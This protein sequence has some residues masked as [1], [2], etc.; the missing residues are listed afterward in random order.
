MIKYILYDTETGKISRV[1]D[2]PEHVNINSFLQLSEDYI[3]LG[4]GSTVG[5]KVDVVTKQLIPDNT[6]AD[7]DIND[8]K[9]RAKHDTEK[10]YREKMLSGCMCQ[11]LG[12]NH[13]YPTSLLDQ[14]NLIASVLSAIVSVDEHFSTPFWCQ[15]DDGVW[16]F[17]AH[18]K[19]QIISVG[20][21]VKS[22]IASL[23]AE[24]EQAKSNIDYTSDIQYLVNN[25]LK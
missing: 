16:E 11:A 23:Q 2:M 7:I 22:H 20:N 14:Q 8:L 1:L 25:Y 10:F 18:D 15:N 17:R 19:A 13:K 4:T 24:L 6:E 3:V 21:A 12:T 9:A 5:M